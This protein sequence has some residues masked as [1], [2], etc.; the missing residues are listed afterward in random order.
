M[1]K[2]VVVHCLDGKILKGVTGD[3]NPNKAIFHITDH[4]SGAVS[5]IKLES[6]KAV[7]FVKSFEGS[8]DYEERYELERP[9]HGKKIKIH[10]ADGETITGF[11]S[12]YQPG[13][14]TFFIFPPDPDSNND[15]IMVIENSTKVIEYV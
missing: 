5:T 7:F 2:K 9:G 4:E 8:K 13:R 6:L 14:G 15:R 10:F 12:A 11:T 1:Q 3:L